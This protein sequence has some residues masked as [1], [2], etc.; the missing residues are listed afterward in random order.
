[1][2]S[3]ILCGDAIEMMATLPDQSIDMIACD[4]PYE[5]TANSWDK[6]IPFE[7]MWKE[8][9]R[10]C[11]GGVVFTAIQPFSSALVMSQ[12]KFY[13]QE[14]IWRKNKATGH[15]NAKKMP[16]RSHEA[17]LVFSRKT[18]I[19]NPQMTTGHA[20][21]NYAVRRTHTSNYGAQRPTEYGGSTERYPQTVQEFAVVNND[22]P[23][24][25][26]PTQKPVGLFEFMIRTYSNE[27]DTVLDFACG[28]GTTGVACRR[29]GR[30]FIGIEKDEKFAAIAEKRIAE[31]DGPLF[32]GAA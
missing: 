1:M 25:Y 10:I 29:T 26:H 24:R 5:V 21:G 7:P 8:I 14:W 17:V 27:G 9:W 23:E 15:L 20:P 19:Y 12:V 31:C 3:R 18:P 4:P 30:N 28:S 16:L 11:R 6:F 13:R 22:A 2:E 32:A